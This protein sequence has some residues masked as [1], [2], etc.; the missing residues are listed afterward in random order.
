M[1]RL[2]LPLLL[3]LVSLSFA[4]AP[5]PK[6]ERRPQETE[7][8]RAVRRYDARLRELGGSWA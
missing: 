8:S 3:A 1:R 7:E 2:A 5:F 6:A 4:P